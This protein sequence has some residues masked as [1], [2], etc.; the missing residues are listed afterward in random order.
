MAFLFQIISLLETVRFSKNEQDSTITIAQMVGLLAVRRAKAGSLRS[1]WWLS[2]SFP[3]ARSKQA[4]WD[5]QANGTAYLDTLLNVDLRRHGKFC[6][7]S[8][9][10]LGSL[11]TKNSPWELLS[12]KNDSQ[13]R[14]A[15]SPCSD[16]N[17]HETLEIKWYILY[18]S[19]RMIYPKSSVNLHDL[20]WRHP[21]YRYRCVGSIP[22]HSGSIAGMLSVKGIVWQMDQG[23]QIISH[24]SLFPIGSLSPR[25]TS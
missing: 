23:Q 16:Q 7:F 13:P 14:F 11:N 2:N 12:G 3:C 6:G 25:T 19:A 15:N 18:L 22:I 9:L 21:R 4:R 24:L 20:I 17:I 1:V 10:P 8:L 5:S